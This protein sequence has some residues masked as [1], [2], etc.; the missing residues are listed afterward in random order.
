MATIP[1]PRI[2]P[3]LPP[4]LRLAI[5]GALVA[6]AIY[7]L[8]SLEGDS[9]TDI[10]P[11]FVP[12]VHVA[13]PQLD[14][15]LLATAKD[16]TPA[17]RLLVET[18]PLRH[19]LARAIDVGPS[20]AAALSRPER[21][22]PLEHLRAEPRTWRSRWLWY[23][24]KLEQL[25]GPRAG[26]SIHE[27]TVRLPDDGFVLATFS[28]L[29]QGLGVGDW[30]RVE[31]F[32]MKL[33]DTAYPIT[34]ESA[35]HL[36]GRA[37]QR[38][39]EDWPPVTTLDTKLLDT[40]DDRSYWPGDKPWHTVA[41]DQTEVLWHLGAFVRDTDDQRTL[42]EWRRIPTLETT[43]YDRLRSNSVARG[44]PMRVFG[45]LIRRQTIAAPANP[46]NIEYWT[47]VYVQVREFGGHLIPIWV[48]KRVRDLPLRATLEVCGHYYR[49]FTYEAENGD[50]IRVPLFVAADLD[51]F[52]LE[53]SS[54]MRE[55]GTW[56]GSIVAVLLLLLFFGQRRMAKSAIE[57]QRDMD[58]RR[59]RRRSRSTTTAGPAKDAAPP[60][61]T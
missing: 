15:A 32:L 27:A 46:A 29:P 37:I 51:V 3:P 48:P 14:A 34:I 10:H 22:V 49:W 56:L 18:E 6:M 35:P 31:G 7:V 8:A 25:S 30:V 4:W 52:E 54:T 59:Q 39:Y 17:E 12:E 24:G 38:D 19:L 28:I 57:H 44:T 58:R 42:A 16:T 26:Y 23:E 41:E 47:T 2:L 5:S 60:T 11:E 33:R 50:R 55:I 43:V 40:V 9:G 1:T 20:V 13:L 61:S 36:V 53:A 45:T 21:P